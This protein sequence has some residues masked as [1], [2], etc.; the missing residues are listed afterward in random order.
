MKRR[1]HNPLVRSVVQRMPRGITGIQTTEPNQAKMSATKRKMDEVYRNFSLKKTSDKNQLNNKS[2]SL[3]C[4]SD[5]DGTVAIETITDDE[6]Q[7]EEFYVEECQDYD[8]TATKKQ[9]I[10]V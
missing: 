6:D 4:E 1:K 10:C 8:N 7:E 2:L 5:D 3:S 9:S